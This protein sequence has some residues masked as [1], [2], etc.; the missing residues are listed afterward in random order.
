MDTKSNH[1]TP[2]ALLAKMIDGRNRNDGA[3]STAKS[4]GVPRDER[5]SLP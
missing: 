1:C 4:E 2:L 3:L 5:E